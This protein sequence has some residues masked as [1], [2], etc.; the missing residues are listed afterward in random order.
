[1]VQIIESKPVNDVVQI[2]QSTRIA[3]PTGDAWP[4]AGQFQQLGILIKSRYPGLTTGIDRGTEFRTGF[5]F[6]LYAGR[7]ATPDTGRAMSFWT[8]TANDWFDK[9]SLVARTNSDALLAAAIAHGC[10]PFTG[11]TYATLGITLGESSEPLPSKW[12]QVLEQGRVF[13][14]AS[15]HS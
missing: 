6:L 7:R 11:P 2:T 8:Q 14:P 3:W 13:D 10:I 5:L 15:K 9:H 4:T 1:M 12:R